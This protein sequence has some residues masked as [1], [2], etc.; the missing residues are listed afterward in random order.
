MKSSTF[1]QK[2]SDD[3]DD[4]SERSVETDEGVDSCT[5][6]WDQTDRNFYKLW[7]ETS[8]KTDGGTS[9]ERAPGPGWTP[10]NISI[11][12][13]SITQHILLEQDQ[14][15]EPEPGQDQEPKLAP[16]SE[17]R[18]RLQTVQDQKLEPAPET[19]TRIRNLNQH[20]ELD[21]GQKPD[22]DLSLFSLHQETSQYLFLFWLNLKSVK[23]FINFLFWILK[24][25]LIKEKNIY[26]YLH[27][28]NIKFSLQVN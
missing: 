23:S 25:Y 3:D 10:I 6:S 20:Q 28:I 15:L 1:W 8:E 18:T 4:E 9:T 2:W 7:W 12:S 17:S 24:F 16:R 13:L 27:K 14:E 26:I 19:G 22:P 5:L 11:S 21:Q